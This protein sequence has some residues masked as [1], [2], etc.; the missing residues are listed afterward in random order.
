MYENEDASTSNTEVVSEMKGGRTSDLALTIE[1]EAVVES[2]AVNGE[3]KNKI[4]TELRRRSQGNTN[5]HNRITGIIRE[6]ELHSFMLAQKYLYWKNIDKY[7][8]C[9]VR[10]CEKCAAA[11]KSPAKAPLHSWD[12]PSSNWQRIHIIFYFLVV[13]DAKSKWMEVGFQRNAPSSELTMEM[14]NQIFAQTGFPEIIVSD[15]ATIFT[16]ETFSNYC[17]NRSISQKFIAPGHPAT[18]GLAERTIQTLKKRL[19]SADNLQPMK[20]RLQQIL[21]RYPATPLRNGKSPAKLYLN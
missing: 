10:D 1:Q 3:F 6:P 12:E 20:E 2:D 16:S 19:S 21:M 7:I 14:L 8:E 5:N 11:Q 9:M 18:N 17:K 13:V 4:E 15:N